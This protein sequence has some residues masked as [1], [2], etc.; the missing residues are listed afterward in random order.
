MVVDQRKLITVMKQS[1]SE[2]DSR[3][4][5]YH[6]DLFDFVAQIVFLEREHE[7]K[8]T[9]IKNKVGDKVSALGLVIYKKSNNL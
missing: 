8:A 2:I 7:Q 1:V 6:K 9:Q 5:G 4:P 3:Y